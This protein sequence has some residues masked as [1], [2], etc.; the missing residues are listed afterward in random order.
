MKLFAKIAAATLCLC[1]AL[2]GCGC[3]RS[4]KV[5]CVGNSAD[6]LAMTKAL[7]DS[8]TRVILDAG[9]VTVYNSSKELP[10]KA[11]RELRLN[12]GAIST[13]K[14][15]L[16]DPANYRS[17]NPVYGEFKPTVTYTFKW[18][19]KEIKVACDFGLGKYSVAGNDGRQLAMYDLRNV[20]ML[21]FALALYPD[22]K[23]LQAISKSR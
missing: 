11:G 9:E 10:E 20:D 16:Q 21:R 2:S 19:R 13:L 22:D 14:F 8:A 7:G 23:L 18:R 3:L 5:S 1:I 6:S 17:N 12:S 15:L 4:H